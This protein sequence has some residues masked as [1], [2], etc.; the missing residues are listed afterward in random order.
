M[1][2]T[3]KM[4]SLLVGCAWLH[5]MWTSRRMSNTPEKGMEEEQQKVPSSGTSTPKYLLQ[6][7]AQKY[8][9]T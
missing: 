3:C 7:T 1:H 9:Q 2:G 5:D 8:R 6:M 4:Q